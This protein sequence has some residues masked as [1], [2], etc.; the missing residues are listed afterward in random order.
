MWGRET[1]EITYKI[2]LN[3]EGLC[4]WVLFDMTVTLR[5]AEA[6]PGKTAKKRLRGYR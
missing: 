4:L 1:Q 2:T 5:A 3:D 6:V